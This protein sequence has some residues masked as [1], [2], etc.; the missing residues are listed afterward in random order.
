M[1][2]G[3]GDQYIK[4]FSCWNQLLIMMCGQLSGC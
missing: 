4:P 1:S 3:K 2:I